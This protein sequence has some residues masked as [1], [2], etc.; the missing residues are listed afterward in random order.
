MRLEADFKRVGYQLGGA[1]LTGQPRNAT[2]NT[3]AKTMRKRGYGIQ[4][5]DHVLQELG[6]WETPTRIFRSTVFGQASGNLP[7]A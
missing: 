2:F 4:A 6:G 5:A 7:L 3:F 1:H